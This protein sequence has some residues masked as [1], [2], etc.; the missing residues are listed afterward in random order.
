M[1]II[2]F[3]AWD[4]INKEIINWKDLI[5][6]FNIHQLFLDNSIKIMQ[7]TGSKDK[8]KKEIYEGDIVT[9]DTWINEGIEKPVLYII[10]WKKYGWGWKQIIPVLT[11]E[12]ELEQTEVIGNI[13]RNPELLEN[14]NE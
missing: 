7:Y 10:K 1:R 3:R 6:R 11:D 4:K 5:K 13:Y 12:F 14:K 8:N 9:H 2:K